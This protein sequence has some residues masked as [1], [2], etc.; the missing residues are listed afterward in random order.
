MEYERI[1]VECRSGYK[2]NEYPVAFTFQGRR[3]EVVKILDR[4]YEGGKESERPIIDYFRVQTGE[5]RIFIL[6]YAGN[7]NE[8]FIRF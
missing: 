3:R 8:W 7:L 4:W 2:V 5:G 1:Q 6:M